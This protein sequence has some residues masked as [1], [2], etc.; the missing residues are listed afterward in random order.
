MP[1]HAGALTMRIW[2]VNHYAG[3]PAHGM[4]YR[5]FYLARHLKN[6]G[7]YPTIV[8]AGFTHLYHKPVEMDDRFLLTE[9]EGIQRVYL[10]TRRYR[11]NGYTRFFNTWDFSRGLKRFARQ[12]VI[13]RP[14][15]I[16]GSSPHL[17][18]AYTAL[19]IARDWGIP[20]YFEVRDL[21]PLSLLE[22]MQLSR[23]HPLMVRWQYLENQL[24]RQADRV[25]SVLPL[26]KEYFTPRGLRDDKLFFMPNGIEPGEQGARGVTHPLMQTLHQHRQKGEFTILYAGSMGPVNCL[27]TIVQ[28]AAI[29]RNTGALNIHFY[30]IG[31]GPEK[32][33]LQRMVHDWS[34]ANVHLVEQM[35]RASL[36]GVLELADACYI[37]LKK[38]P[39]FR[40]GVCPNKLL[41]YMLAGKPVLYAI[42]SG[43]HPVAE[44]DCG[45]EVEPEAPDQLA[46][47][48]LKLAGKK[49]DERQGM[50]RRGRDYVMKN[51]R[52]EVLAADFAELIRRDLRDTIKPIPKVPSSTG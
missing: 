27:E 17:A 26:T 47:A 16:L 2:L 51:H 34:L 49:E 30:L 9:E 4:G 19:R 24:I 25:V 37:G 23:F 31:A 5:H 3:G 32:Q 8:S 28:A 52:Y 6:H 33:R 20:F 48:I 7:I 46:D 29:L 40:F 18:A 43:N 14:E 38:A 39:A 36:L 1:F 44:T 41:E 42:N 12:Q 22:T 10:R 21:L 35:P 45:I 15:L 13:P 50:G 11:G